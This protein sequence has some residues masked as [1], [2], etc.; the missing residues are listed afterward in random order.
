MIMKLIRE[1]IIL[2]K[3]KQDTDPIQDM[4]I[5]ATEYL[6]ELIDE[7]SEY[8]DCEDSY[9]RFYK[10]YCLNFYKQKDIIVSLVRI[11][12]F[13]AQEISQDNYIHNEEERQY[14]F[15]LQCIDELQS[16]KYTKTQDKKITKKAIEI[17]KK[18]YG[19]DIDYKK[20]L[21]YAS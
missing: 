3:F 8:E 2:E 9:E 4:G 11:V 19:I 21:E 1:H 15:N 17:L 12:Y 13:T 5:G 7:E 6:K 16:E 20:Y 10:E 14:I 18:R